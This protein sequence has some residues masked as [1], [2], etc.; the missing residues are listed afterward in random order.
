[1]FTLCHLKFTKC[2]QVSTFVI[3]KIPN[4]YIDYLASQKKLDEHIIKGSMKL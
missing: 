2:L 3:S 1:M 4:V